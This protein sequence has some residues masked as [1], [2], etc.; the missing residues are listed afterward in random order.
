MRAHT[1]RY[2]ASPRELTRSAS[3]ICRHI[4]L[5]SGISAA[6]NGTVVPSLPAPYVDVT[7]I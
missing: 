4:A 3:E 2:I 6:V 7:S 5:T 1:W